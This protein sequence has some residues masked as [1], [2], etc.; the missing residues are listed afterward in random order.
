MLHS[1]KAKFTLAFGTLIVLLFT[2]SGVFLIDSKSKEISA[3]IAQ[4][5]LS[6]AHFASSRIMTEYTEYLEPGNF[7]PF[8]RDISGILRRD[9][10]I[11]SISILNYSGLILYDSATEVERQYSGSP[12]I[13]TE[14][15]ALDRVQSINLSVLL[16]NGRTVYLKLDQYGNSIPTDINEKPVEDIKPTDRIANIVVPMNNAYALVY[17]VNYQSLLHKLSVAKTQIGLVTMFGLILT[18]V[19]SF[20]LSTSITEPIKDLKHGA[21]MIATGDFQARVPVKT[22]DE[23]GLLAQTFNTMAQE[24]EV[25]TKALVYKERVAK[26][27]ELAVQ[28]QTNLLPKDKLMLNGLDIAGGLIPATEVGGDA[29]DYI[30]VD[31]NQYITY[32]GDVTGHGVAAGI[33][34]SIVNSLIYAFR[35]QV[36]LIKMVRDVNDVVRRKI[37]AKVFITMALT[38]W[39]EATRTLTYA[40]A[41]HPPILYYDSGSGKITDVRL[42]GMAIGMLEDVEKLIHTQDFIMKAGDVFVMYSDG[43]VEANNLT[44][45]QF[46]LSKL[47]DI[48]ENYCKEG[49]AAEAIKNS[50][51]T[52]VIEHISGGE[53]LDDMTVVVMKGK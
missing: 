43:I 44:K 2:A 46:G 15:E 12:R 48:V 49:Q 7:L 19:V 30:K 53:Y 4:T 21:L 40:N 52:D 18:L 9:P 16:R 47:K 17:E 5:S 36:D 25:S 28:I 24:L 34:S 35:S 1:L 23:L 10:D 8:S 41:G 27:L 45:E 6:F 20:M 37:S 33:V 39:N 50:I 13:L 3:D 14:Q 11:T 38:V 32:L 26:E 22:K 29:F 42:Q 31:D 51:L